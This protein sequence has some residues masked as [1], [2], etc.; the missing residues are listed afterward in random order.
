MPAIFT[1][2]YGIYKFRAIIC[3]SLQ[4]FISLFVL[5]GAVPLSL[6]PDNKF[7]HS[8]IRPI[9]LILLTITFIWFISSI[10]AIYVVF[11]DLKLYLRVHICFNSV[12]FTLYVTKLVILIASSDIVTSVFCFV[13]NIIN[14]YALYYEVKFYGTFE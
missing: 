6:N 7:P 1:T 13:V 9:I 5:V 14:V 8:A 3:L 10:L 12:I 4:V 11:R 2:D